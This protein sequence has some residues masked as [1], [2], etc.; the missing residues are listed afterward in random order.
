MS[1]LRT[2]FFLGVVVVLLPTDETQQNRLKERL[3]DASQWAM[4]FCE[5]NPGTCTKGRELRETFAEKAEFGAKLV[6]AAVTAYVAG[7]DRSDT[8]ARQTQSSEQPAL[9]GRIDGRQQS[10]TPSDLA[11]SWRGRG[12]VRGGI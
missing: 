8:S 10:L 4:T 2:C 5:R 7:G 12:N 6:Y 9:A 3:S 11:P 1:V